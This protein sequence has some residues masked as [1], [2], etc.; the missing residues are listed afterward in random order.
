MKSRPAGYP[1]AVWLLWG[2]LALSS[3]GLVGAQPVAQPAPVAAVPV[4]LPYLS[5]R[6]V[7]SVALL[8]PPPAAGSEAASQ[9]LKAVLATQRA[10]HAQNTTERAEADAQASCGRVADVLRL[11][12]GSTVA[13]AFATRAALEASA[14]T[15]AAKRYW[16][17]A[18]PYVV[19][20]EVERPGGIATGSP[21]GAAEAKA[22]EYT[23]Y[24]S[25]HAACCRARSS[26]AICV[27]RAPA[28][29][30][31]WACRPSHR[32]WHLEIVRQDCALKDGAPAL[33]GIPQ[34]QSAAD[35]ELRVLNSTVTC[36][37][38]H[39]TPRNPGQIH[40]RTVAPQEAPQAAPH[41]RPGRYPR[42][43][44]TGTRQPPKRGRASLPGTRR[45]RGR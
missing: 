22:W 12:S 28:C 31:R 18:R 45:R 40:E 21:A 1:Y 38:L 35:V 41:C 16:H 39:V 9:D 6:Q 3:A 13:L 20:P 26:R 5:P 29:V 4:A 19:S 15:G 10:A 25:G 7:D 17:R 37:A 14:A 27:R 42:H 2:G 23:S 30:S 33:S 8:E 11:N 24:P 36:N 32:P 44:R 43:G 34:G